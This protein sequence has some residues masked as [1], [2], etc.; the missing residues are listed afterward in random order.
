MMLA[1]EVRTVVAY[2]IQILTRR[3]Q[4]RTFWG[5]K[6]DLYFNWNN[7]FIGIYICQ[8][9]NCFLQPVHFTVC[10]ANWKLYVSRALLTDGFHCRDLSGLFYWKVSNCQYQQIFF[11]AWEVQARLP[12]LRE[13]SGRRII[14]YVDFT[15]SS[16]FQYGIH[17]PQ[18][19]S[20]PKSTVSSSTSQTIKS[21]VFYMA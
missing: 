8:N 12:V 3:E 9:S 20:V 15:S 17:F 11:L 7:G 6:N 4:E 2:G 14:H 16:C 13:S 21:L 1:T 10:K 19:D 18:L 5:D